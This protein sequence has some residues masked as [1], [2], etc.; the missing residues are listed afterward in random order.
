MSSDE[1][2]ILAHRPQIMTATG[3][4]GVILELGC[5]GG[6]D[7]VYL[8][9]MG[10]VVALDIDSDSLRACSAR[11]P[12]AKMVRADLGKGIPFSAASF[13]VI[14]ASLSLHYFDWHT[15][16]QLVDEL[17]RCIRPNGILIARVNSTQDVHYGAASEDAIEPGY[18]QVGNRRKR[19]FDHASVIEMFGGWQIDYVQERNILR[20]EKP[21]WV[22]EI[23]ARPSA[24]A[25]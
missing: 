10:L 23:I 3:S 25:A 12:L 17:G 16:T 15:T 18:F 5:G 7:T 6:R 8:E 22:W 20:Y 11:A 4:D 19:F 21:K 13:Q 24:Y 9:Q 2:W 1:N 14:I